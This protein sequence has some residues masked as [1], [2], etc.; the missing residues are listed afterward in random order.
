MPEV[1]EI[2]QL[3]IERPDNQE[4]KIASWLAE[5]PSNVIEELDLAEGSKIAITLKNGE[6]S[7]DI[8]PPLAPKQREISQRILEKD[9]KFLRS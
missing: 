1:L 4:S 5:I 9:A 7:G 6:V 8:L 2:E 3:E